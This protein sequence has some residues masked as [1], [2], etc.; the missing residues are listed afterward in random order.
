MVFP[1]Y[2]LHLFDS[3]ATNWPTSKEGKMKPLSSKE[4]K[5]RK[6]ARRTQKNSRQKNR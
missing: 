6:A 3:P 2:P 1:F 4:R 5:K